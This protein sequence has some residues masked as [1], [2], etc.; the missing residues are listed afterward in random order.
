MRKVLLAAF[1]ALLVGGCGTQSGVVIREAVSYI[2]F[3]GNWDGAIAQFDGGKELKVG[4]GSN[5]ALMFSIKP[6]NHNLKVTK[7]GSVV[8]DRVLFLSDGQTM[9]VSIP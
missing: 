7:N 6:G 8:V 3:S 9:E 2:Q 1:T 5:S 4:D